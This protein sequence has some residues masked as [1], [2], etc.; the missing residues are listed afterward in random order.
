MLFTSTYIVTSVPPG[1]KP[2]QLHLWSALHAV[3]LIAAHLGSHLLEATRGL[4]KERHE[5]QAQERLSPE[6]GRRVLTR[7]AFMTTIVAGGV[8]LA[9][10]YQNTPLV[11][12]DIAGLLIGRIPKEERGRPGEFRVATLVGKGD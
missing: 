2:V 11:N 6:S 7:R 1:F 3:P 12:K 9:L 5:L 4:S 8:G 10:A